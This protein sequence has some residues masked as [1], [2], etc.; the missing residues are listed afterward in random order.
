M[1]LEWASEWQDKRLCFTFTYFL[2]YSVKIGARCFKIS[3]LVALELFFSCVDQW[4]WNTHACSF[5]VIHINRPDHNA[6]VTC[7]FQP[8]NLSNEQEAIESVSESIVVRLFASFWSCSKKF[9]YLYFE[10]SWVIE[11]N[12]LVTFVDGRYKITITV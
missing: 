9:Y 12:P 5:E 3:H 4:E 6:T 2:A 10:T 7:L 8:L 1:R 11:S